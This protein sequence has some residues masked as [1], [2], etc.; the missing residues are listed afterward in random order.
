MTTDFFC[1]RGARAKLR[2]IIGL[3]LAGTPGIGRSEIYRHVAESK[4]ELPPN[5]N[6][7]GKA[8]VEKRGGMLP[9]QNPNQEPAREAEFQPASRRVKRHSVTLWGGLPDLARI[10]YR[11]SLS[12]KLIL[13][14]ATSAPIPVT[15]DVDMPSDVVKADP[16]KGL[17]VAYPAFNIHFD[18]TWGPHAYGGLIWHPFAGSWYTSLAGGM[19]YL[20]ITGKAASPLR[21]CSIIE[22]AKEPPCGNDQAAIQTRN[23]IALDADIEVT[24]VFARAATGW[25]LAF[26]QGFLAVIELGA[27]VPLQTTTSA[28]VEASI[29]APDGTPSD[30]S[31][32]LAD[33]RDKSQKDLENKA[34]SSLDPYLKKPLPVLAIGVGYTF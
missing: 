2:L 7:G 18:M 20:R 33:L 10:D 13:N 14:L 26:G 21:I 9:T 15:V 28:K 12:S 5:W 22:A 23:L 8:K 11:Y 17:A 34:L 16:Q 30:L 25:T 32:A 4:S 24:S 27:L 3:L 1:N 29:E 6:A 19:R 31:G